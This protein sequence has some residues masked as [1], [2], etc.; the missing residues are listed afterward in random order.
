MSRPVA[1]RRPGQPYTAREAAEELRVS[2]TA[3]YDLCARGVLRHRRVGAK[4]LIPEGAL[5]EFL[6]A[7]EVPAAPP[8]AQAP[9]APDVSPLP[10]PARRRRGRRASPAASGLDAALSVLAAA[11]AAGEL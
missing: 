3:V 1:P 10:P 4:Y 2:T 9:A 6:A 7:S 5:A 11:R 8:A